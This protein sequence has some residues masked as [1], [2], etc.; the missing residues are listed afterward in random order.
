LGGRF[1]Y[2]KNNNK[3]IDKGYGT[4]SPEQARQYQLLYNWAKQ[5]GTNIVGQSGSGGGYDPTI[6]YAQ[7]NRYVDMRTG[8]ANPTS[9][10]ASSGSQALIGGGVLDRLRTNSGYDPTVAAASAERLGL[11]Q[12]G[13]P[14]SDD[15][16]EMVARQGA[17]MAQPPTTPQAPTT[18]KPPGQVASPQSAFAAGRDP[19]K[20]SAYWADKGWHQ[21][22]ATGVWHGPKGETWDQTPNDKPAKPG[23]P[24]PNGPTNDPNGP[25]SPGVP[26]PGQP[27]PGQPAPG[28]PGQPGQPTLPLDPIYEAQRQAAQANFDRQ[29]SAIQA[30]GL[31]LSAEEQVALARLATNEGVDVQQLLENTAARGTLNSSIYG[32][33]RS[34]L[35]TDAARNRQDLASSIADALGGLSVQ[36]GD[37][38]SNYESDL[39]AALMGS[40]DR[41][42]NDVN[43]AVD[44]YGG[45]AGNSNWSPTWSA[46]WTPEWQSPKQRRRTRRRNR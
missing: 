2:G 3:I 24:G 9:T 35:A 34:L 26:V 28:Q 38:Q 14:G 45:P 40:A 17:P 33:D 27:V 46:S 42:A 43:A 5:N 15:Y 20:H 19:G 1:A 11:N 32:D 16:N 10:G 25:Q 23:Q 22:D 4:Y 18:P 21:N 7:P 29:M 13:F 44:Q 36:A 37:V 31:R 12:A 6:L 8:V 30:S 41:S 39:M